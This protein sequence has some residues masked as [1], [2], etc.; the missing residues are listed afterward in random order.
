[1]RII[2]LAGALALASAAHADTTLEYTVLHSGTKSGAQTTVLGDDGIVRVTYTHRDNGRGPDLDERYTPAAD[3]TFG[4]YRLRGKST[5][6]I[7]L[8][9]IQSVVNGIFSPFLIAVVCWRSC[10][11]ESAQSQ[12]SAHLDMW[13]RRWRS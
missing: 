12:L 4:R 1:M 6:G 7:G 10:V 9:A 8:L 11:D 2:A 5:W 3:G 13:I